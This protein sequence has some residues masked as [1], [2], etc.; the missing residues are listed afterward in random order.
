MD[1]H[2]ELIWP[3]GPPP[4]GLPRRFPLDR[5]RPIAPKDPAY[6]MTTTRHIVQSTSDDTLLDARPTIGV[7]VADG[8]A[9]RILAI[10]GSLRA[11]S[12]NRALLLAA[13]DLA[14]VGVAVEIADLRPIPFYDADVEADGDPEAVRDFKARVRAADAILIASP[15][16]NG[17]IPG[18]L[19]NAIDWVSRPRGAAPLDGK[20]VGIA[21]ATPSPRGGA[22]VG[23][24]LAAVLN[25]AGAVPLADGAV[26][27][28]EAPARFAADGALVDPEARARL[29]GLVAA[30][31]ETARAWRAAASAR[32]APTDRLVAV[33][34]AVSDAVPIAVDVVH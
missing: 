11:A 14:P 19:Q 23:A 32:P 9:L 15:E 12:H 28:R 18:V 3:A 4:S 6:P 20:P 27:V 31:A 29:R 26:V 10:P 7:G 22:R 24:H 13:R 34:W 21:T 25:S 1:A 5:P 2:F 33:R 17:T 30:L 16:Y 8:A